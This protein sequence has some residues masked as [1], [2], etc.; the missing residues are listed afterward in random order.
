MTS[1]KSE[2]RIAISLK[3]LLLRKNFRIW[4]WRKRGGKEKDF[5]WNN[6]SGWGRWVSLL[7]KTLKWKW[8]RF[9]FFFFKKKKCC[10]VCLHMHLCMR[11]CACHLHQLKTDMFV[12]YFLGHCWGKILKNEVHFNNLTLSKLSKAIT[13]IFVKQR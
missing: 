5:R 7:W 9:L 3:G 11:M 12:L 4:I 6:C 13:A 2:V 8:H 10:G 1:E